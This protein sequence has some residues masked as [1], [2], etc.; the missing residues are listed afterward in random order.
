MC[1][2]RDLMER[3][4]A[5][6]PW[7]Q[8]EQLSPDDQ[9][10]AEALLARLLA[11]PVE[12]AAADR[13]GRRPPVRHWALL[14]VGAVFAAVAAVTATGLLDSGSP[15]R[16]RVVDKAVAAATQDDS[17][18]HVLQ[19]TRP[20]AS[21]VARG[22]RGQFYFESW[23]SSDGRR[24]EKLFA[25]NG[26]SRG[27]LLAEVAGRR[28]TGRTSGPLLR[29]D[30]GENT[31]YPSGFGEPAG[32]G[33]LATLDP[34]GDPGERLRALK[35]QGLLRPAGTI[36]IGN[37]RAYRLVSEPVRSNEGEQE[38]FDYLVDRKTYLPLRQR[39]SLRL[40][41]GANLRFV[42]RFL[43]YER[44]PL[45]A[46]SEAQLD[47]DPHPQATCAIGAGELTG[48][49]KLGFPNPCPRSGQ[50]GPARAP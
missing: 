18:Y 32:A 50:E 40:R 27:R 33:K 20:S 12:A 13:P 16:A 8:A 31:L 22:S 1:P 3:L 45:D 4:V 7:P 47:L 19:R 15:A 48:A 39:Y 11:T 25:A 43:V 24:H 17:V 29:Y 35:A 21:A 49:R 10:E 23:Y 9:R 14:A 41:S 36:T 2:D 5:A 46:H 26:R 34:S 38:R 28:R 37:R 42:T 44:L 30:P 6:D